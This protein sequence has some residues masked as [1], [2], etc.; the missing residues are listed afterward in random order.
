MDAVILAAGEGTRFFDSGA[1]VYKQVYQYNNEPLIKRIVRLLDESEHFNDICVVLGQNEMCNLAIRK[2]LQNH[3]VTYAINKESREDNN[4]LSLITAIDAN[5]TN[6][7]AGMLV[8]ESD[9][10]FGRSDINSIINASKKDE[11][12][13]ANIGEK[14]IE[15][16]GGLLFCKKN[17]NN[18]YHI[19]KIKIVKDPL[20]DSVLSNQYKFIM[21][22]FGLTFFG[23]NALK[24][25]ILLADKYRSK[26]NIY[27]HQPIMDNIKNFNNLSVKMSSKSKSFN[28]ISEYN[29]SNE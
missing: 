18:I 25:Y 6:S 2:A 17:N 26:K 7:P 3:S 20:L 11:I 14:K 8:V 24:Q 9:C 12:I 27:F 19:D 29:E 10:I 28:T 15:Q 1:T 23:A 4:F 16:A 13:W 22:M 21:K 5:K